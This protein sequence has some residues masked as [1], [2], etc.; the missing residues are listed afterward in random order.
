MG[1]HLSGYHA[2]FAARAAVYGGAVARAACGRVAAGG[3]SADARAARL[4][5][6]CAAGRAEY[7]A[8]SGD[9]VCGSVSA[10]GRAGGN[11]NVHANADGAA[12]HLAG[13]RADAAESGVGL[14]GGG[15]GGHRAAG[16][17]AHGA[18]GRAGRG[19]GVGGFGGDG[20]GRVFVQAFAD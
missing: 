8:V 5:Q 10:H 14:G 4:G 2:V 1:Q 9:A 13:W 17:V 3:V 15:R 6:D 12:A 19:G 20:V 18:L 16:I 7:R 11:F